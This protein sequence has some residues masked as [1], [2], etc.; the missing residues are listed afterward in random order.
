[1]DRGF[2]FTGQITEPL[3]KKMISS[4]WVPLKIYY[5]IQTQ[6]QFAVRFCFCVRDPN[7]REKGKLPLN[8]TLPFKHRS[9]VFSTFG[10]GWSACYQWRAANDISTDATVQHVSLAVGARSANG[11]FSVFR[12]KLNSEECNLVYLSNLA[13]VS[14]VMHTVWA[15]VVAMEVT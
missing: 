14:H 7:S 1:M 2:H 5:S 4:H 8:G 12:T 9:V 11:N 6:T 15:A 13:L 3:M 10:H